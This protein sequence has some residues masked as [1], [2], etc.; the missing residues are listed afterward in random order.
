MKK[1]VLFVF[2]ITLVS[3]KSPE[4]LHTS[5]Y[6][7]KEILVGKAQKTD[8]EKVP[9]NKWFTS[10]YSEYQ[11]NQKIIN[12][13]KNIINEYKITV[14][15]GTWC[16]DS[17]EQV[18]KLYKILDEAGYKNNKLTMFTVYRKYKYYKPVQPYNIK[19]VPT[20]IVYQNGKEKGRIIEY[21]M[22][23]IEG[24]L[25]KIMTTDTYLHE[26]GDYSN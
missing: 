14:V 25:L 9:Y 15:M 4:R 23:S 26:L 3:C 21:P 22:E 16:G 12:Q 10:G 5:S 1:L 7:G 24:D 6:H 17:R 18:P 2:I 11:P 20:I 8:F 19:R 13:L